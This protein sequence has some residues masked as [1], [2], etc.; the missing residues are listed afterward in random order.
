MRSRRLGEDRQSGVDELGF[1]D[2]L[3]RSAPI[4]P[5]GQ[6]GELVAGG[7]ESLG[8]AGAAIPVPER[9]VRLQVLCIVDVRIPMVVA[10]A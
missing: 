10:Q 1:D 2:P 9:I 6:D 5:G 4:Q 7:G 3:E 8:L